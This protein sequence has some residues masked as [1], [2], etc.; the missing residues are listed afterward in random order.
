VLG[1]QIS[2][3]QV[4]IHT[5]PLRRSKPGFGCMRNIMAMVII[6][7][8]HSLGIEIAKLY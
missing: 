8:F 1:L 7:I 2:P 4:P 3:E 6:L 5:A